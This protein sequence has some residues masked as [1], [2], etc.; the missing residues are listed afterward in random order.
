VSERSRARSA[1]GE[2]PLARLFAIG[3][4]SSVDLLHAELAGRGW[5][6][7]RPAYGFALLA[8]REQPATVTELAAWLGMTK[9]AASKLVEAMAGAGY[10]RR[11]ADAEDGRAWIVTLTS[12]GRRLLT[13]V[14]EIYQDLERQWAETI[15]TE[16]L[17]S[18]RTHLVAMLGGDG[19][20]PPVRPVW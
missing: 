11:S 7:L 15:G 13:T 19:E 12:R 20:L 5:T 6:D 18:V 1:A 14:E 3:Y 17:A 4:R 10:V 2:I 16:Q 8:V 9:Q